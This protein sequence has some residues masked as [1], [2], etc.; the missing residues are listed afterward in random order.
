[1]PVNLKFK[2]RVTADPYLD[3]GGNILTLSNPIVATTTSATY[4]TI[5]NSDICFNPANYVSKCKLY[6][7]FTY[8]VVNSANNTV[9]VQ[10]WRQDGSSAVSGSEKTTSAPHTTWQI[11]Q[12][13]W[14]DFSAETLDSFQIQMKRDSS[15][16]ASVNFWCVELKIVNP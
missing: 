10:V 4:V 14:I 2:G 13:G 12:T 5:N 7:R 15:G 9:S 6:A 11:L 8:H 1:M 3:D 16:T